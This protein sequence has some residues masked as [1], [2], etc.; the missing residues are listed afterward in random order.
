MK[1]DCGLIQLHRNIGVTDVSVEELVD[2]LW[3]SWLTIA[4][5]VVPFCTEPHQL[6]VTSIMATCF[7]QEHNTLETVGLEPATF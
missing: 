4:K 1:V 3:K 2:N 5:L 6:N 7:T